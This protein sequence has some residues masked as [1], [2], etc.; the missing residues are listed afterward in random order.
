MTSEFRRPDP[1]RQPRPP[2]ALQFDRF[3]QTHPSKSDNRA[4]LKALRQ[5]S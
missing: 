2:M 5:A 3:D 1:W 4:H